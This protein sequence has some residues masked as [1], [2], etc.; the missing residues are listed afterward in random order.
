MIS[1]SPSSCRICS[2]RRRRGETHG[3]IA[4]IE[5]ILHRI[6]LLAHH[7]LERLRQS[8]DGAVVVIPQRSNL[9]QRGRQRIRLERILLERIERIYPQIQGQRARSD[10]AR[11]IL[12]TVLSR[13][14]VLIVVSAGIRS[15]NQR[16]A[17][18]VQLEEV[19][20][21]REDGDDSGRRCRERQSSESLDERRNQI[22]RKMTISS[23]DSSASSF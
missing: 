22:R 11:E 5:E 3:T 20:D 7:L 8:R 14:K 6:T 21:E 1:P 4:V 19:V 18:S 12:C 16:H 17:A 23:E 9:P 2:T 10:N 13:R 15:M